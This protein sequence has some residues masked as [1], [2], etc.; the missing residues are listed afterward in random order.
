MTV[1]FIGGGNRGVPDENHRPVERHWH[2]FRIMLYRVHIPMN[3]VRT[4]SVNGDKVDINPTTI[5][6]RPRRSLYTNS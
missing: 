3:V 2:I 1:S 4:H 6:S 5:Q